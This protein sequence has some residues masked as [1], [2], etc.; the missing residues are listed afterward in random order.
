MTPESL[1]DIRRWWGIPEPLLVIG[2][3]LIL[4]YAVALPA[5][6]VYYGRRDRSIRT[7]HDALEVSGESADRE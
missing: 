4:F 7:R 2:A 3:G 5:T 1:E 6:W